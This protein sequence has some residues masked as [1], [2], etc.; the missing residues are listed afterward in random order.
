MRP[1]EAK[2][3]QS[4]AP[5]QWKRW[6]REDAVVA[7]TRTD[8]TIAERAEALGR[9]VSSIEKCLR[10]YGMVTTDGTAPRRA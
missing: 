10:K 7:Y 5:N 1:A 2:Y 4:R 6:N 9:S 8:L 3:G